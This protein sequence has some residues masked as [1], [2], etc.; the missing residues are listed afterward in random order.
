MRFNFHTHTTFSDGKN[1]PEEVLQTAL[2]FGFLS[3]G[4][5]DHGFTPYDTRYCMKDEDGY[6]AEI[7]RLKEKYKGKIEVYLGVE[8]DSRAQVDRSKFDYIIGSCHYITAG[9]RTLVL[10]SN[11]DY[12]SKCLAACGGDELALAKAYYEPFVQYIL[13]RRPDVIGHFDLLTKFDEKE[14]DRFL[15]SETYWRLAQFYTQEALRAGSIFEVNTGLITRGYRTM[16]C[17]H[18]KL[19]SIIKT[20]GGKVTLSSDSHAAETLEKNF[21]QAKQILQDVGF[22]SV[23][24]LSG[25]KWIKIRL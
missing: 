11:Y 4:F 15:S 19:L 5:S 14:K 7:H 1:T 2:S 25:G 22:D 10:D 24:A 16:P 9:D 17:P 8:E 18:E 21:E 23:Y 13:Q 3:I 20:G 12:F 6:V